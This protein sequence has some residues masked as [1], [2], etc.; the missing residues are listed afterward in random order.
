MLFL[1]FLDAFGTFF[2]VLSRYFGDIVYII[3][4][5]QKLIDTFQVGLS[6]IPRLRFS[7]VAASVAP[8]KRC[9]ISSLMCHQ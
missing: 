8:S 2:I 6:G 7:V 1:L 4:M 3:S 5:W 9:Q